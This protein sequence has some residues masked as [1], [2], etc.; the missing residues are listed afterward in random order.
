L[1]LDHG[2]RANRDARS[3]NGPAPRSHQ[4]YSI[5]KGKCNLRAIFTFCPPRLGFREEGDEGLRPACNG[6]AMARAPHRAL[7]E[8]AASCRIQGIHLGTSK[9]TI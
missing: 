7:S 1:R 8:G 2:G 6:L 5:R 9:I 3:Q 4:G